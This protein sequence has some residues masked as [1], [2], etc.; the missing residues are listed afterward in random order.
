MFDGAKKALTTAELAYDEECRKLGIPPP[1]REEWRP[2]GRANGNGK[3]AAAG[4]AAK[5]P[6]ARK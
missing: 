4:Q 3:S 1:V 2:R 5:Q 6:A